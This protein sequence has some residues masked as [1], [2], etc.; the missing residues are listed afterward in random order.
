M[1]ALPRVGYSFW[2]VVS[3][4][5]EEGGREGKYDLSYGVHGFFS[6]FIVGFEPEDE[7]CCGL[8]AEGLD[9]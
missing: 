3:V 4:D 6:G 7:G 2:V 5:G 8:A 9:H 1:N